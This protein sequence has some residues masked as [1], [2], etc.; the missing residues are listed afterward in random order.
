MK[1]LVC[2]FFGKFGAK[3]LGDYNLFLKIHL[4]LRL[5]SGLRACRARLDRSELQTNFRYWNKLTI[6]PK[7]KLTTLAFF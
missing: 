3:S 5:I 2:I 4:S 7:L 6:V 1:A